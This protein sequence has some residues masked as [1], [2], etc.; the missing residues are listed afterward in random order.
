VKFQI[1]AFGI[2]H[3]PGVVAANAFYISLTFAHSLLS[4]R[5][6]RQTSIGASMITGADGLK[7]NSPAIRLLGSDPRPRGLPRE[8]L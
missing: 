6:L 8:R 5:L 7:D 1:A 2:S 4:L 3:F